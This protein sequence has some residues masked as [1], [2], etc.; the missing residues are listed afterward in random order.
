MATRATRSDEARLTQRL[1]RRTRARPHEY[2][3][4]RPIP[5]TSTHAYITGLSA[6]NLSSNELGTFGDW[7]P[8]VWWVPE[9]QAHRAGLHA[10]MSTDEIRRDAAA[11]IIAVLGTQHLADARPALREIGHG[12]ADEAK[13]VWCAT[14]V[15]AVIELAWADMKDNERDDPGATLMSVDPTSVAR[16]LAIREQWIALHD[17]AERVARGPAREH[18]LEAPWREWKSHQSPL[19]HYSEPD[20]RWNLEELDAL[21]RAEPN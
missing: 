19:A 13:P 2:A 8:H 12:A 18:G 14:H 15:R 11:D 4:K 17:I 7:H 5:E 16:W 9:E 3:T 10:A 21:A 6:L 1:E 20:I